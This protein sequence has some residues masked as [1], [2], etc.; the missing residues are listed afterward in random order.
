MLSQIFP[1]DWATRRLK[2][3]EGVQCA[4]YPDTVPMLLAAVERGDAVLNLN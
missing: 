3:H 1:C 4:W 2:D